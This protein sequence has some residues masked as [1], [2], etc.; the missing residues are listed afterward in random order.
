[1]ISHVIKYEK[2]SGGVKDSCHVTKV[3]LKTISL[4]FAQ[5]ILLECRFASL[6]TTGSYELNSHISMHN[7]VIELRLTSCLP[8]STCPWRTGGGAREI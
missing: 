3:R 5:N 4:P 1:M 8:A 7:E 6:G 2:P